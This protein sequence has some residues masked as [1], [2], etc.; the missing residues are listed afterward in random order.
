MMQL[1]R[2]QPGTGL[3]EI[4]RIKKMLSD[5]VYTSSVL[6]SGK[7]VLVCSDSRY[8]DLVLGQD[9]ATAYLEQKDL[10]HSFRV[11]ESVLLRIKRKQAI[12]VF[13]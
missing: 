3:L 7:A 11:L 6:G 4:D 9:L 13:E 5:N 12:T 8:M 2:I 10:N 1:Q